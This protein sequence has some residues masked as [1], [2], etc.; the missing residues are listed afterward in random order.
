MGQYTTLLNG[1]FVPSDAFQYPYPILQAL[2]GSYINKIR[3]R[4]AVFS[5]KHRRLLFLKLRQDLCSLPL[6]RRD[7][8]GFHNE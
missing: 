4:F 1:L 5:D 3:G 6:K 8:M 7:K 2:E